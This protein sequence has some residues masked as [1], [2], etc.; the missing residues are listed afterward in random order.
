ME[1]NC[2]GSKIYNCSKQ[3]CCKNFDARNKKQN[4]CWQM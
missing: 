1:R 4:L 3:R 2:N